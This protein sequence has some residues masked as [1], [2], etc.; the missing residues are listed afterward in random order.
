MSQRFKVV[1]PARYNSVRFPGKSLADINGKPMIQYVHQC[2]VESGAE[3]VVIATDSTLIGMA[4][5]EFGATVCMTS[6]THT[7]GTDRIAEVAEKLGWSDDTVVVNLQGDEPLTPPAIVSQ[8]ALDLIAN[9]DAACATLYTPLTMDEDPLDPNIV[10]VI[11]DNSGYAIYFSR[12]ALPYLRDS[13]ESGEAASL[14]YYRHIGLYAYRVS[15]LNQF[16]RLSASYLEQ[17][18]KLEQLRLLSNGLRIHVAE[19]MALPGMGVDTPDDL[20]RVKQHL[21]A[22]DVVANSSE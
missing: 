1:I 11:F 13:D 17:H 18:E 10:K 5:E 6:D 16:N 19:A 15:L 2:A 14:T 9:D 21:A 7:S 12:A 3:D 22:D 4:A 8:V 20:E